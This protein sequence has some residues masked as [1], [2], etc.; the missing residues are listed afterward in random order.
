M[1]ITQARA[2][3][4]PELAPVSLRPE[5]VVVHNRWHDENWGW[6]S[7]FPTK[8]KKQ[9]D[10]LQ[11]RRLKLWWLSIGMLS[12]DD[13]ESLKLFLISW[14]LI[15]V[16]KTTFRLKP[17]TQF[18]HLGGTCPQATSSGRKCQLTGSRGDLLMSQIQKVNTFSLIYTM[19]LREFLQRFHGF[20]KIK[21]LT[22]HQCNFW[23]TG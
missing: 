1:L 20:D 8:S 22:S 10:W 17:L 12:S 13:K 15:L 5:Q 2:S 6:K 11:G 7:M 14:T 19:G 16:K 9:S 3:F 23:L 21:F 18:L 4:P